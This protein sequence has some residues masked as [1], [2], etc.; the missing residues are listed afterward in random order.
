VILCLVTTP[1]IVGAQGTATLAD[2]APRLSLGDARLDDALAW[3]LAAHAQ[4]TDSGVSSPRDG[5]DQRGFSVEDVIGPIPLTSSVT[6]EPTYQ[7]RTNGTFN[8]YV[9]YRALG[10]KPLR[11]PV[12]A[13]NRRADQAPFVARR[14]NMVFHGWPPPPWRSGQGAL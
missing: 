10:A 8:A 3:N 13:S 14:C 11:S 9:N 5:A 7:Q 2:L 1:V 6:W 4:A 12:S